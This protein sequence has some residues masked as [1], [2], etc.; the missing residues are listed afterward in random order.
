MLILPEMDMAVAM[1][2]AG[3][4]MKVLSR[5][6]LVHEGYLD[7]ENQPTHD[8]GWNGALDTLGAILKGESKS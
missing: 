2:R 4:L 1:R 6:E 7:F 3:D 8:E 5:L